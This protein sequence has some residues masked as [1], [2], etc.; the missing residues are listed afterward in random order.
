MR[1]LL[2]KKHKKIQQAI[3]KKNLQMNSAQESGYQSKRNVISPRES[4]K[5]KILDIQGR[6]IT[7]MSANPS[8][9]G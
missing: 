3:D 8:S 5:H 6:K 9:Q 2:K 1:K 4:D 7:E